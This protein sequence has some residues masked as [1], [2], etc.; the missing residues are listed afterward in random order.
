M[1]LRP[2]IP[3]LKPA[4]VMLVDTSYKR[5]LPTS[6]LVGTRAGTNPLRLEVDCNATKIDLAD[7]RRWPLMNSQL[8]NLTVFIILSSKISQR[9]RNKYYPMIFQTSKNIIMDR[10]NMGH[11]ANKLAHGRPKDTQRRVLV[12]TEFRL[13]DLGCAIF[14]DDEHSDIVTTEYYGGPEIL[15]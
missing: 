14:D 11:A 5:V 9:D 7:D 3:I 2:Y 12:D 13:I 4:N 10:L 6:S 8:S 1:I 15:L